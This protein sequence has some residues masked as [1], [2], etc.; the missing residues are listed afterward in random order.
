MKWLWFLCCMLLLLGCGY[1]LEDDL[2]GTWTAY[3]YENYVLDEEGTISF[4]ISLQGGGTVVLTTSQGT[5]TGVWSFRKHT[6]TLGQ[7][8]VTFDG[9]SETYSVEINGDGS[10]DYMPQGHMAIGTSD[11]YEIYLSR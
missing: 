7:L 6:A 11:Q 1:N 3:R 8:T 5:Q 2:I 10:R 9:L 4:R